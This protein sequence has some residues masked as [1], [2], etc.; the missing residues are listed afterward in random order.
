MVSIKKTLFIITMTL[1]PA[2]S[3]EAQ[4]DR[5][6]LH[7]FC[8]TYSPW[9]N[10]RG[11]KWTNYD[12]PACLKY[13]KGIIDGIMRAGW[14]MTFV[15]MHMDPYWSNMPGQ[16]VTGENDISAFNFER[17][18]KYLN[19]VFIPMAEYAV[20]KGLY[21]VM[22]PPGVC[23][24][25]ISPGD[26]Y[27]QYLLKVWEHV[28]QQE[29]LKNNLCIMYELANE[30][31]RI[32][33]A[34]GT[35]AGFKELRDYF[36]PIVDVIRKHAG[37]VVLVPGTGWQSQYAGF[38]DYPVQ[39]NNVGYAVH[40]YPGW[41]NGGHGDNEVVVNYADFKRGWDEQIWPVASFAP[42]VV[43][44]MDWAPAK[45]DSSWGKSVTGTAGGTGF[46]AN[47]RRIVDETGNVSWVVFTDGDKLAKYDDNAPDGQTFL[48]DPEACPRP[49]YRWY[50]EYD[51][52]EYRDMINDP[53]YGR[54]QG[55]GSLFPL[56]AAGFDPSIWETGTFDEATGRLHTG[57]YGF[58]GWKYANGTDLS[59]YKY[60]VVELAAAQSCN[61]SFRLF[62]V[63]DY[64]SQPFMADF[65]YNTRLCIDLHAMNNSEGRTL[66]PSHIYI[67]G[68]WTLGNAPIYIS[69]VFLSDDGQTPAAII[70]VS[71]DAKTLSREYFTADG[72]VSTA[73]AGGLRIVRERMS[74]GTVRVRK[75]C[76]K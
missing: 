15:R 46:G 21:V 44:E 19:E 63:N 32:K 28:A 34:N 76:G 64:W 9:F 59:G 27:Q 45:Y 41:Y 65:G 56:T 54:P 3:S 67:A 55:G 37:N 5:V 51:T 43:T 71:S 29:K 36:Q 57:Q 2:L 38:A 61:A 7:G 6:N 70:S 39:G 12:V 58:G 11:T 35:P 66:D 10:E 22:R 53:E 68:F 31:I 26:K 60:L 13:N 17:F 16:S 24:D 75:V 73:S 50:R 47:F 33:N 42:V 69:R 49:C 4:E 48:T 20:G 25:E 23:P 30:P 1:G 40:C 14:K 74:D 72:R 62:D 52:Q 18:K 8:Q